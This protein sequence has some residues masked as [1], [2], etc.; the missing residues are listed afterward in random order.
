MYCSDLWIAYVANRV[1]DEAVKVSR[2]DCPG[3]KKAFNSA[4]LHQCQQ[5]SLHD[6]LAMRFNEIRSTVLRQLTTL[7]DELK[8][9]LPSSEN[10]EQDKTDA[11]SIA[12][13]FLLTA[14]ADSVYYGRFITEDNDSYCCIKRKKKRTA[15]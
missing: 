10:A 13:Q 5:L 3:H 8:D 11:I 4:L 15:L 2:R 1:V 12:R 9:N 7:Y 6:K 14:T